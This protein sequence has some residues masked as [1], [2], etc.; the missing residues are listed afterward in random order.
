MH[1]TAS[2]A[3]ARAE[4]GGP[5]RKRRQTGAPVRLASAKRHSTA[6][7][8]AHACASGAPPCACL[9]RTGAAH[10]ARR[11][12]AATRAPSRTSRRHAC[13]R[14]RSTRRPR[15]P[16]RGHPIGAQAHA[17][18]A[19]C[20]TASAVH[21]AIRAAATAHAARR[22]Q[23]RQERAHA[24]WAPA[25][26]R[27]APQHRGACARRAPAA[28]AARAHG[29]AA[30]DAP[31]RRRVG[32]PR[33][34]GRAPRRPPQPEPAQAS[35]QAQCAA[36]TRRSH[37]RAGGACVAHAPRG[38][39]PRGD[40]SPMPCAAAAH[41]GRSAHPPLC[42]C[43]SHPSAHRRPA[44][45]LVPLPPRRRSRTAAAGFVA[46]AHARVAHWPPAGVATLWPQMPA[47]DRSSRA[48]PT[49][50]LLRFRPTRSSG[51]PKRAPR[52]LAAY[53]VPRFRTAPLHA[54]CAEP[55]CCAA[56]HCVPPHVRASAGGRCAR[57]RGRCGVPGCVL[58][59]R[60]GA[61]P[62]CLRAPAAIRAGA[63]G[64]RRPPGACRGRGAG[65]CC[66]A[67]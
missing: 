33:A 65:G 8:R 19:G 36:P 37:S 28:K 15:A 23:G 14:R 24:P 59:A 9:P 3:A 20:A 40:R 57:R 51:G 1:S 2:A 39:S 34:A 61:N 7:P 29:S 10:A 45:V 13:F 17:L 48:R 52:R 18:R 35:A 49:R 12:P 44:P 21:T 66:L 25:G 4:G 11:A 60:V 32:A 63:A 55:V 64:V 50:G 30:R 26:Y 27:G 56:R 42:R 6:R 62:R 31:G 46:R 16:R 22:A 38:C 54:P 58:R 5:A 67:P 43:C 47:A 53:A 41:G